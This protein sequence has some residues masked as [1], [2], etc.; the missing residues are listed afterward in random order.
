MRV[1]DYKNAIKLAAAELRQRDP[2]DVARA[3]G[4]AFADGSLRFSYM[5]REAAIATP[6]WTVS[7]A[8]PR[9]DEEFP[10]TD[11]VLALHYFQGATNLGLTG[12]FIAYREFPGGEFYFD[13][14]RRRAETPLAQAFGRERG[15][16]TRAAAAMGG[17]ERA[18]AGDEALLFRVLPHIEILLTLYWGDEEFEPAGGVL[19]D[20][21]A[22]SYLS[23]EDLSWL[24][25]ALVYRL[26]GVAKGLSPA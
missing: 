26:M 24:G 22:G 17:T 25:S 6:A 9:Q 10:L 14:F 19:F 16:L 4:A 7:W 11:Q 12:E 13:A 15:L 18:G 5:L 3:G 21:V 8:P 23:N 20:R 2:S 1:D